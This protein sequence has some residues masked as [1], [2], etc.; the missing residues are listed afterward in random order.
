MCEEHDK[1]LRRSAELPTYLDVNWADLCQEGA[2]VKSDL[3]REASA[4]FYF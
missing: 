3:W 2:S 1:Q 4:Y